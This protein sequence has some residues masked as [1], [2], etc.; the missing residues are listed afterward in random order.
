MARGLASAINQA[1]REGQ[2]ETKRQQ[3]QAVRNAKAEQKR[4]AA[5]EK[6]ALIDSRERQVQLL[7]AELSQSRA[8][9]DGILA[10]TLGVDDY[11][12]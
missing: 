6:A 7:N 11:F 4:L 1:I 3:A 12:N 5:M 2:R 10:A 9:I 8:E